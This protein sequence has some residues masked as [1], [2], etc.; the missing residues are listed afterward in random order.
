[1]QSKRGHPKPDNLFNLV[2]LRDLEETM[3]DTR[4][5]PKEIK[6]RTHGVMNLKR[7]V[8]GFTGGVLKSPHSLS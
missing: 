8:V 4:G 7:V 3:R 6:R 2:V 5:T 1:M